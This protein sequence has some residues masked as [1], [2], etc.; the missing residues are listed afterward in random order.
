MNRKVYSAEKWYLCF[1][2]V[3]RTLVTEEVDGDWC[4]QQCFPVVSNFGWWG[5]STCLIYLLSSSFISGTLLLFTSEKP[6]NYES[7]PYYIPLVFPKKELN[8]L[9]NSR[10]ID[11]Y[12]SGKRHPSSNLSNSSKIVML[13]IISDHHSDVKPETVFI[14]HKNMAVPDAVDFSSYCLVPLIKGI[15]C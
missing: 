12:N 11:R 7:H 13:T 5:W 6:S 1:L 8:Q 3:L 10:K 15:F 2:S 4:G 14:E 9:A